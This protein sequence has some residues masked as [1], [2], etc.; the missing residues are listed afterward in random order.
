MISLMND[1]GSKRVIYIAAFIVLGIL[2]Q[3]LV[4]AGVEIVVINL[5]VTDF[6]R[7]GLGLSWNAWYLIHSVVGIGLLLGGIVFGW[8]QG[9]YWWRKIYIEKRRFG[10]GK[11]T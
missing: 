10:K 3:Q 6:E 4:H 11:S 2:L 1:G 7:Y 9:V 5:L 8:W